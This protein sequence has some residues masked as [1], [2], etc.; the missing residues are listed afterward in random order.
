MLLEIGTGVGL[1]GAQAD[2]AI[3]GFQHLAAHAGDADGLA[4][5]GDIERLGLA[6]ADD[7]QHHLG[8]GHAA[9]RFG[10]F[11]RADRLAVDGDDQIAGENARAC[12][13]GIVDRRN[14]FQAAVVGLL[15]QL[16]AD[17]FIG[18][19]GLLIEGFGVFLVEIGA[20][21]IQVQQQ[22]TDGGL[23]QLLVVDRIHIG[24]AHRV[25][26]GDVAADLFQRNP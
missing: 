14:D 24:G 20:V 3:A 4:G 21:R 18:A 23:H 19:V 11:D 15:L 10:G 25:V 13:R 7:G 2:V 17:A 16:H 8:A 1:E 22:A 6:V 12:G 5:D 9:Q 26:D